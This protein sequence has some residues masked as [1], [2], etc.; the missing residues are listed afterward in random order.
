MTEIQYLPFYVYG[1]GMPRLQQ[2]AQLSVS[3]TKLLRF[4]FVLQHLGN[5]SYA[6]LVTF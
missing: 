3:K 1:L 2:H 5:I 6:Q 4:S